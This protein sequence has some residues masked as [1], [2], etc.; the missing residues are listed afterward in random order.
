MVLVHVGASSVDLFNSKE[1]IPKIL[2]A[3][4]SLR[5]KE[6]RNHE[7]SLFFLL[8]PDP[9]PLQDDTHQ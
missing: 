6:D 9:P 5:P 1:N 2:E 4:P 8:Q 7:Y 3:A